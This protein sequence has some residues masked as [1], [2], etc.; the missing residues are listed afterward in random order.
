[1]TP[2]D[3]SILKTVNLLVMLH[4]SSIN[5]PK[6]KTEEDKNNLIVK[7]E[8]VK[9]AGLNVPDFL[10]NLQELSDKGYLES[11]AIYDSDFKKEIKNF[12]GSE[13][14]QKFLKLLE[15]NPDKDQKIV[16]ETKK[17]FA[18][19]FKDKLPSDF[20]FD[21]IG[22]MEEEMSV[23]DML[24]SGLDRVKSFDDDTLATIIIFPFRDLK[25]LLRLL[26][27]GK[28][29]SEVE[30]PGLWYDPENFQFHIDEE[31]IDT[32]YNSKPNKEH[33]VLLKGNIV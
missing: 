17:A 8:Y 5:N 2:A 12:V 22:F 18:K 24:K 28:K 4:R 25:R 23:S 14:E 21:E 15:N 31:I 3:E 27:E 32:S 11:V 30:D 19:G 29:L 9:D 33:F 13:D 16:E 6:N 1:M 20:G 10:N 26:N 7:K